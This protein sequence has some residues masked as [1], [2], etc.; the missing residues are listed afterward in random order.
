MVISQRTKLS[1]PAGGKDGEV[2]RRCCFWPA[3]IDSGGGAR[4][5]DASDDAALCDIV[6]REA[7]Y[8]FTVGGPSGTRTTNSDYVVAVQ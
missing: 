5:L 2:M 3:I 7:T 8:P 1:E 4:L 6:P